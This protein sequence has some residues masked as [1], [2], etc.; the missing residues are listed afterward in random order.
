MESLANSPLAAYGT[1]TAQAINE[2]LRQRMN[3]RLGTRDG[4]RYH[5]SSRNRCFPIENEHVARF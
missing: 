4:Q 5:L 1:T 2:K 3:H